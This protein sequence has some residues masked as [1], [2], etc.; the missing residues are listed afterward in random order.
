MKSHGVLVTIELKC[1]HRKK[2]LLAVR[3]RERGGNSENYSYLLIHRFGYTSLALDVH[4]EHLW[5]I[6]C[7]DQGNRPVGRWP[8]FFI[9]R[10][11]LIFWKIDGIFNNWCGHWIDC[12][13]KHC[14]IKNFNGL[15]VQKKEHLVTP[16]IYGLDLNQNRTF[17]GLLVLQIWHLMT[18]VCR[19]RFLT[20]HHPI[21]TKYWSSEI[22]KALITPLQL[23]LRQSKMNFC[24]GSI[25]VKKWKVV[26]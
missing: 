21:S 12:V 3:S 13:L 14:K 22:R 18:F 6:F 19:A 23:H 25:V 8:F 1:P 26:I 16:N 11:N 24:S 20:R 4:R 2:K 10:D 17:C 9:F 15:F 7:S 5:H